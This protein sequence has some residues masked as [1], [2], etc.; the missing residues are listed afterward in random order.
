MTLCSLENLVVCDLI[1][2]HSSSGRSYR[3]YPYTRCTFSLCDCISCSCF[4]RKSM[5][6]RDLGADCRYI[7][8]TRHSHFLL[9]S[10]PQNPEI[11]S[12]FLP[13]KLWDEEEESRLFDLFTVLGASPSLW[14]LSS[15]M[16]WR[17]MKSEAS[18]KPVSSTVLC[19]KLWYCI[20]FDIHNE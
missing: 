13:S 14:N 15:E 9:G 11:W 1:M 17:L 12:P 7:W 10:F 16:S 4:C 5:Q 8:G 2:A 20:S 3:K 18:L 19:V 6:D